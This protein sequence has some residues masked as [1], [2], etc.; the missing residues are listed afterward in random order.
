MN[1]VNIS[2]VS[3]QFAK[4]VADNLKEVFKNISNL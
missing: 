2:I 4:I 1:I 3:E